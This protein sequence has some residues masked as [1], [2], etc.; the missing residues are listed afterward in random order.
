VL[1]AYLRVP[2]R[3]LNGWHPAFG[4]MP[5]IIGH[6]FQAP[7]RC[8]RSVC[9]IVTKIVEIDIVNEPSFCKAR[10]R[11]EL[12]PPLVDAILGPPPS[13]DFFRAHALFRA[14]FW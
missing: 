4:D 2:D 9:K 13:V 14:A 3:G 8:P 5:Q 6:L 10:P 11:F 12:L 7:P 1:A